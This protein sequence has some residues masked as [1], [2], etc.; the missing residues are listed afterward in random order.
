VK[1]SASEEG[2]S[3]G[4]ASGDGGKTSELQPLKRKQKIRNTGHV[5]ILSTADENGIAWS[6]AS[7]WNEAPKDTTARR[8]RYETTYGYAVAEAAVTWTTTQISGDERD[9]NVSLSGLA[10]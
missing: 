1:L 2:E 3:T 7:G 9:G 10:Y 8:R 4:S 6:A 5:L